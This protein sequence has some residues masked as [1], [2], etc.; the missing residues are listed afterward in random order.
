MRLDFFLGLRYNNISSDCPVNITKHSMSVCVEAYPLYPGPHC[1]VV[2][3]IL[4][5]RLEF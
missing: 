4:T 2:V 3:R 1:H 5:Y